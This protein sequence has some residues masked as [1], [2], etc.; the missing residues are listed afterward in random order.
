MVETRVQPQHI[1][2][3]HAGQKV[4]VRFNSF[5]HSPQLVVDGR[6]QSVSKDVLS[7]ADNKQSYYLARVEITPKGMQQLGPRV[8]QPGMPAEVVVQTGDRTVLQYLLHPLL[9]RLGS[10]MNEV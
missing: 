8:M 6:L 4:D 5:P 10:A 9:R 3:L 7:D 1:D 2:R